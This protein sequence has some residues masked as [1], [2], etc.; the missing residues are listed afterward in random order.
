[1]DKMES[2]PQSI[3]QKSQDLVHKVV[4]QEYTVI[5]KSV[6]THILKEYPVIAESIES[7][8]TQAYMAS[9]VSYVSLIILDCLDTR[10]L[11]ELSDLKYM[12]TLVKM[13]TQ[14]F[15]VHLDAHYDLGS[16]ALHELQVHL[17]T[18]ACPVEVGTLISQV[19]HDIVDIRELAD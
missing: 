7:A 15:Q 14:E 8:A 1:M 9:L 5:A 10:E 4:S 19:Y 2:L 13:D 11:R 3:I 6:V 17:L 12:V 16:P 18:Q